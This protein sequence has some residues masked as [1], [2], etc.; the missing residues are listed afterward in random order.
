[1]KTGV[2]TMNIQL[3]GIYIVEMPVRLRLPGVGVDDVDK[4]KEKRKSQGNPTSGLARQTPIAFTTLV[5]Q[6]STPYTPTLRNARRYGARL[7]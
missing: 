1:V 3:D 7:V 5:A 4:R 2:G 6:K